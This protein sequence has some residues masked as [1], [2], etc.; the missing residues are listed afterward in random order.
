MRWEDARDYQSA[1]PDRGP[2][3]GERSLVS[4]EIHFPD[5]TRAIR[6]FRIFRVNFARNRGWLPVLAPV[7]QGNH[8]DWPLPDYRATATCK[9]G[10]AAYLVEGRSHDAPYPGCRCG[11]HGYRSIQVCESDQHFGVSETT[12]YL[13]NSYLRCMAV[14]AFSGESMV[15]SKGIRAARAEV[16]AFLDPRDVWM[17]RPD[18][19]Y[20]YDIF[21]AG[22]EKLGFPLLDSQPLRSPEA[23]VQLAQECECDSLLVASEEV[24][25]DRQRRRRGLAWHESLDYTG[26][27]REVPPERGNSNSERG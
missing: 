1:P 27:L 4:P 19:R 16:L 11:L 6:G 25:A 21:R 20:V 15:Y 23:T 7:A 3:G 13:S 26:P 8:S 14:V 2:E 24:E 9:K 12:G 17:K 10:A 5:R 22:V 18:S